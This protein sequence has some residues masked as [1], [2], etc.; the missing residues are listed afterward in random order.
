MKKHFSRRNFL[1]TAALSASAVML[2]AYALASEQQKKGNVIILN[3]N[4]LKLGLMSYTIAKDWD[5]ET[6]IKNCAETKYEHVELRTTHACR[7]R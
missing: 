1:Q 5:I 7:S 3:K 2:P 6:I 4:P